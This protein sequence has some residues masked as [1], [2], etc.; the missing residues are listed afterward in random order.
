MYN[1]YLFI[2]IFFMN[3][4]QPEVLN[5]HLLF[6]KPKNNI[7]SN[8]IYPRINL[9]STLEEPGDLPVFH[10]ILIYLSGYRPLNR[11]DE[12]IGIYQD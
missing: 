6:V 10:F 9:N 3:M 7:R 12:K 4:T 8:P 11:L 5:T 2:T 1:L